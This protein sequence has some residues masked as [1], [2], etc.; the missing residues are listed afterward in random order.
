MEEK[1]KSTKEKNRDC[2]LEYCPACGYDRSQDIEKHK[3]SK[4]GYHTP[5][6]D[7]PSDS[8]LE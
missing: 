5:P 4:C 2:P 6:Q 8:F 1:T 3:C 7:F